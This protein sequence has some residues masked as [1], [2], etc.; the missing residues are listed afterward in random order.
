VV[1][2]R[3]G[4]RQGLTLVHLSAQPEP[5]LVTDATAS[6]HF[7]AQPGTFLMM[8]LPKQPTKSTYLESEG[9]RV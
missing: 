7:L 9:G 4:T 5:F 1:H 6:V 3:H 2:Q 8:K